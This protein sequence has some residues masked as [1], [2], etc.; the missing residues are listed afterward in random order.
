MT[1][2]ESPRRSF[3]VLA[4]CTGVRS[5]S[6]DRLDLIHR[7]RAVLLDRRNANALVFFLILHSILI[8]LVL[9]SIHVQEDRSER[10][11]LRT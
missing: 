10:W 6:E 11:T 8:P 5:V 9:I 2:E 4:N 1:R 3:S 7:R